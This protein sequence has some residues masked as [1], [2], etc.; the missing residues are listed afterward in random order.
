MDHVGILYHQRNGFY[1]V[2]RKEQL[3]SSGQV[4]LPNADKI[5]ISIKSLIIIII[6]TVTS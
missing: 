5:D 4:H 2:K 3:P 1:L 6:K